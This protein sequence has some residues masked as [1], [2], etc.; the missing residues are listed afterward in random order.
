[1]CV[2]S[3][4]QSFGEKKKKVTRKCSIIC[5][6]DVVKFVFFSCDQDFGEKIENRKRLEYVVKFVFAA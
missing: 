2:Y 5:V 4:D 1:M 6:F 3:R